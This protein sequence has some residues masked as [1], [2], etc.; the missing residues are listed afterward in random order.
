MSQSTSTTSPKPSTRTVVPSPTYSESVTSSNSHLCTPVSAT[1]PG[2][3]GSGRGPAVSAANAAFHSATSAYEMS[4]QDQPSSLAAA[5]DFD[6]ACN[7]YLAAAAS[8]NSGAKRVVSAT[9]GAATGSGHSRTNSAS[10]RHSIQPLMHTMPNGTSQMD[11]SFL[12]QNFSVDQAASGPTSTD[13]F[14]FMATFTNQDQEA[15]DFLMS[16]PRLTVSLSSQGTEGST[17][18]TLNHQQQAAPASEQ[19]K[20]HRLTPSNGIDPSE[21]MSKSAGHSPMFPTGATFETPQRPSQI[22]SFLGGHRSSNASFQTPFSDK[23]CSSMTESIMGSVSSTASGQSLRRR[24]SVDVHAGSPGMDRLVPHSS[25]MASRSFSNGFADPPKSAPPHASFDAMQLAQESAMVK[26]E[27]NTSSV[28]AVTAA[29]AAANKNGE[30]WPDDVEVA[31]WEALRLIPKLGRRKVLVHGKPCGRNELIADYIERKTNK[32]RTR[33]QVSSHIQVLKNIKK[34]DPE[35]QHLIAEPVTEEDFYMP[36]GGMMYAQTL[37]GY[38]YGGLG[39]PNPLLADSPAPGL[40]SPYS[41]YHQNGNLP[42]TSPNTR[43]PEFNAPPLSAGGGITTAFDKLS[44]PGASTSAA[45]SRSGSGVSCPILPATFSMWAHCSDSD[46]IHLYT[47]LDYDTMSNF[48]QAD[49]QLPRVPLDMPRLGTYR[50]PRMAEMYQRLPCQFLHVH[51]PMS[52][53][54][55]DVLLPKF[56]RFSTQLS[57]TSHSDARLTSVTTVYSHG[58]RVLSLMEPL[59]PPRRLSGNNKR[60]A[61][62]VAKAQNMPPDFPPTVNESTPTPNDVKSPSPG[63]GSDANGTASPAAKHRFVHQAPFATDFWA[64]FLSRNH[65]VHV[66]RGRNVQQSFCKEP[67]ERAALGMAVSGITIIQEL[68]DAGN[69]P[70]GSQTSES[71]EAGGARLLPEHTAMRVSPGSTIGDVVLVISWELEC[72]ESLGGKPGKPVVSLITEPT[73][74]GVSPMMGGQARLAPPPHQQFAGYSMASPQMQQPQLQPPPPQQLAQSPLMGQRQQD[75]SPFMQG[76]QVNPHSFGHQQGHGGGP[77]LLRKRGL[78]NSKPN[79]MLNIPPV[80]AHLN[81]NRTISASPNG[82]A[83]PHALAWGAMQ[84][85]AMLGPNSP[86]TPAN[87]LIGTPMAPPPMPSEED[88]RV[89]RERLHRAWAASAAAGGSR[90]NDFASPLV[91]SFPLPGSGPSGDADVMA[92]IHK[93]A[94]QYPDQDHQQRHAQQQ[95]LASPFAAGGG[96]LGLSFAPDFGVA[97]GGVPPDVSLAVEGIPLPPTEDDADTKQFI[98]NLLMNIGASVPDGNSS[99]PAASMMGQ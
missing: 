25:V 24:S 60:S 73:Q 82:G 46:D 95:P 5:L 6:G 85:N 72:V 18:T 31:F 68:V 84:R 58:K 51:V 98:D 44:L 9:G 8:L 54:R 86:L 15:S 61:S 71:G 23:T 49:V 77:S 40:L 90:G 91:A 48:A 57:L 22:Q 11:F 66:Y 12:S 4:K 19:A 96:S 32:S 30:V 87:G 38:G 99:H 78:S 79:L 67:S 42:P 16:P 3:L 80:P 69:Q 81:P 41:P 36:A 97:S 74:P 56:D 64:D 33:K 92:A 21:R 89:H 39:G 43:S 13:D 88:A 37:A 20:R 50:F 47:T 1:G 10:R 76:P 75:L 27:P 94:T 7:P 45:G 29:A 34:D 63:K 14:D 17:E 93:F 83:S 62:G 2:L 35:F 28:T 26:Q 53:P 65:P 59:E 55:Q 52:I 70:G